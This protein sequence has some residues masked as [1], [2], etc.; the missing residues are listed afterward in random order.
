MKHDLF[1]VCISAFQTF[2]SYVYHIYVLSKNSPALPIELYHQHASMQI[3]PNL[4]VKFALKSLR[5]LSSTFYQHFIIS[6][7]LVLLPLLFLANKF[8]IR[9]FN[10]ILNI[11]ILLS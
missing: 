7:M 3:F 8:D 11:G 9:H 6:F 2:V 1:V 5:N 4:Y 10:F